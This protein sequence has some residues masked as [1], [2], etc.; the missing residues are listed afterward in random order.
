MPRPL[1]DVNLLPKIERNT[2]SHFTIFIG[3]IVALVVAYGLIGFY[4]FTTKSS[5][6]DEQA[7]YTQISQDNEVLEAQIDQSLSSDDVDISDIFSFI[8]GVNMRTSYF[9][10]EID[11]LLPD[12]SYVSEY[13]YNDFSSEIMV[14]FETFDDISAYTTSLRESSFSKDIF[15]DEIETFD[16]ME[17]E[18]EGF[19]RYLHETPRHETTF[20]IDLNEQVLRGVHERHE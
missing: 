14:H 13:V 12:D 20:T 1:P 3:L 18:R 15:V 16:P 9:L 8:E 17:D 5:L 6:Q 11:E 10:E 4:Y 19:D 2:T 7:T